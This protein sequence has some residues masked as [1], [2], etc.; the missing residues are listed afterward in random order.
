MTFPQKVCL[1]TTITVAFSRDSRND[2]IYK[3]FY[4]TF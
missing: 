4:P 2:D 1:S 3:G